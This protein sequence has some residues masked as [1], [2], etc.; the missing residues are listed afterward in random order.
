M[1]LLVERDLTPQE[2]EAVADEPRAG[3]WVETDAPT[4]PHEAGDGR[5]LTQDQTDCLIV[6]ELGLATDEPFNEFV[7]LVDP[8]VRP[9]YLA[10]ANPVR[11]H[12]AR[13]QRGGIHSEP[14]V[15]LLA[16]RAWGD[17]DRK[18][19]E[20]DRVIMRGYGFDDLVVER[21]ERERVSTYRARKG[22]AV[23]EFS[24]TDSEIWR[25]PGNGS[26]MKEAFERLAR[27]LDEL[28]RRG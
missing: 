13:Q 1:T 20:P 2:R 21:N 14:L 12:D 8:W 16:F 3:V 11:M 28:S 22:E 5:E 26:V 17:R 23:A 19:F 25:G 9:V 18:W 6:T 10:S 4:Y 7:A 15:R 27:R 24:I